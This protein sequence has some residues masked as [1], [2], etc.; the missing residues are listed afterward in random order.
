MRGGAACNYR[1]SR[2]LRHQIGNTTKCGKAAPRFGPTAL[3]FTFS[4]SD[5]GRQNMDIRF[6]AP[7]FDYFFESPV[8]K[9]GWPAIRVSRAILRDTPDEDG[10]RA[11]D[12]RPAH[13]LPKENG[14]VRKGT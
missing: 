4:H 3:N 2:T 1:T 6:R 13:G 10:F 8:N 9:I 12:F 7:F 5:D 11:N 14:R